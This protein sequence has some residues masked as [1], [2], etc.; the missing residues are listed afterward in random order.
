MVL[1]TIDDTIYRDQVDNAEATLQRGRPTWSK[2]RPSATRRRKNGS[3]KSL[4]PTKAIA[5]SDY[6]L[7]TANYK[8]AKASVASARAAVRQSEAQLRL[9][10]TNM[11][12]TVIRSPVQGMVIARLV[13]VGQT[14][15]A[16]FNAPT[17]FPIARDLRRMEVLASVNESDIG[18]I[19]TNMPVRFKV[20]TYPG[21]V[22]R[23]TVSQIRLNANTSGPVV[24]YTVVVSTDNSDERLLPYLT[25]SVHFEV[26]Q[27]PGVLLVPNAALRWRPRPEEMPPELREAR[28]VV[29]ADDEDGAAGP[30]PSGEPK[31][32]GRSGNAK[33]AKGPRRRE[34]HCR[35]WVASGEFVRPIDVEAGP[36][37]GL[38]TEVSGRGVK[39]GMSVV[40]G[41][42]A[43]DGDAAGL[44]SS[45]ATVK[46]QKS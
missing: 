10:R 5:D 41:E 9:A 40:V 34:D 38:F 1:A 35:L 13:N 33:G 2:P 15:V 6:D 3:A 39:E 18:R 24:T 26:D 7:V 25:A 8:V 20:D 11:G 32:S 43:R 42:S 36:T 22:F 46:G 31:A 21:E 17:L 27:R 29:L 44:L 45:R 30:P 16:S 12:Y 28:P 4:L 37:D 19:R 23:G 14:V